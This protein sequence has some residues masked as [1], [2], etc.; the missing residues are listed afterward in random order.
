[1]VH[2]KKVGEM[3]NEKF[4]KYNQNMFFR[5]CAENGDFGVRIVRAEGNTKYKA[6]ENV[7]YLADFVNACKG[8]AE[9]C[10]G[11]LEV[12]M[13]GNFEY[14]VHITDENDNMYASINFLIIYF[15]ENN[16]EPIEELFYE[17]YLNERIA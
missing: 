11:T 6:G 9:T 1:M 12:S 10:N 7:D 5:N 16:I 13:D 14:N 17:N 2:I 8:M 15:N 3:L 4:D